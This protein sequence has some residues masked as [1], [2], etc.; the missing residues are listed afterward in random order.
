MS[1]GM[2]QCEYSTKYPNCTEAAKKAVQ[3][4]E[5]MPSDK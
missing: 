3:H 2:N 4:K 1:F 5:R